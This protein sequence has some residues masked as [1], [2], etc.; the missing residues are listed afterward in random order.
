MSRNFDHSSFGQRL[1]RAR[2]LSY[3]AKILFGFCFGS[4]HP[5]A[6]KLASIL[7]DIDKLRASLAQLAGSK[8]F[9]PL[10]TISNDPLLNY[11]QTEAPSEITPQW[12]KTPSKKISD[13]RF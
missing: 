7:N 2:L 10:E 8:D 1:G 3:R 11:F 9:Y 12:A 4:S 5:F 13:E 6:R